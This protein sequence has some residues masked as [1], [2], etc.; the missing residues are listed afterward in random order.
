MGKPEQLNRAVDYLEK[1]L[2][3]EVDV[4]G[5]TREANCSAWQFTRVF[6]Y[7]AG[8]SIGDYVRARVSP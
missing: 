7:L 8:M 6:A 3:D 4:E 5:A 1:H 2:A